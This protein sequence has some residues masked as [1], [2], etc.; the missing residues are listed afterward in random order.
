MG[1]RD[2]GD[3]LHWRVADHWRFESS[4]KKAKYENWGREQPAN[5]E[6]HCAF[7]WASE[8]LGKAWRPWGLTEIGKWHDEDCNATYFEFPE[9]IY[10]K[11]SMRALC[12][13]SRLYFQISFL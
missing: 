3:G 13:H 1:L 6:E 9:P 2:R 12:K 5:N 7:I 11:F 8:G 10:T 4:G